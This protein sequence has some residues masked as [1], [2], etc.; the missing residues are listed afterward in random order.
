M[1]IPQAIL[2]ATEY[3]RYRERP[4]APHSKF[5]DEYLRKFGPPDTDAIYREFRNS[6]REEDREVLSP[7]PEDSAIRYWKK[8][9]SQMKGNKTTRSIN[10]CRLMRMQNISLD[11]IM[12][13]TGQQHYFFEK[14]GLLTRHNISESDYLGKVKQYIELYLSEEPTEKQMI[15]LK[16]SGVSYEHLRYLYRLS[17]KEFYGRFVPVLKA[18]NSSKTHYTLGNVLDNI[19]GYLVATG[20]KE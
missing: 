16:S 10:I 8:R 20:R 13:V 3:E 11:R 4:T 18:Y 1:E 15:I 12:R 2:L 9:F 19:N 17:S 7:N 5:L 6:L 14:R